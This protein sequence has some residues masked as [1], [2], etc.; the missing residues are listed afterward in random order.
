MDRRYP[1]T[2]EQQFNHCRT[3]SPRPLYQS[4][5]GEGRIPLM[6]VVVGAW[7]DTE[8]LEAAFSQLPA[9]TAAPEFS[10]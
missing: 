4:L 2:L 1:L 5:G 6:A 10:W 3:P 8:A 9:A 7:L